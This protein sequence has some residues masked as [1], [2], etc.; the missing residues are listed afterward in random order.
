[1]NGIGVAAFSGCFRSQKGFYGQ[2][3]DPPLLPGA[4]GELGGS[5]VLPKE[6]LDLRMRHIGLLT[7]SLE[8]LVYRDVS[9]LN[10]IVFGV[11]LKF[12]SA[13]S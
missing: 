2:L 11:K 7:M 13:I 5:V 1:M 3:R 12:R 6:R 4:L 9:P 10:R 8:S